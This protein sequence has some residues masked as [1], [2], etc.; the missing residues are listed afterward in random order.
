MS[1]T[2]K[3]WRGWQRDDTRKLGFLHK[4]AEH[5]QDDDFAKELRMDWILEPIVMNLQYSETEDNELLR[6]NDI[7]SAGGRY[8]DDASLDVP[9]D[10]NRTARYLVVRVCWEGQSPTVYT[11]CTCLP[12]CSARFM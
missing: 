10:W 5:L 7:T 2:I 8:Y 4:N 12:H 11:V 6:L 3:K 9:L 1:Q